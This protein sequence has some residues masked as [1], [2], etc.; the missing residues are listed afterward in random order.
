M[1]DG[2][3]CID[4]DFAAQGY[5]ENEIEEVTYVYLLPTYNQI[6]LTVTAI[7][8]TIVELT[9]TEWKIEEEQNTSVLYILVPLL[10]VGSASIIG[11]SY[12]LLRR[13]MQKKQMRINQN[14]D[15]TGPSPIR[16]SGSGSGKELLKM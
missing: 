11:I 13:M 5:S 6:V 12:I 15:S 2:V 7:T 14:P 9:T 16:E 8:S 10:V 3:S 1:N 4:E